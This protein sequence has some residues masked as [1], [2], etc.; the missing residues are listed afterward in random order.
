[1]CALSVS[2][3]CGPDQAETDKEDYQTDKEVIFAH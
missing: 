1:L 3:E 2:F